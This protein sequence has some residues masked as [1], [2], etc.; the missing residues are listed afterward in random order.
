MFKKP[1]WVKNV[2]AT[3]K[4]WIDTDTG[5][6]LVAVRGLPLEEEPVKPEQ[7]RKR[8]RPTKKKEI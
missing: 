5:E 3:D 4:G 6:L 2:K 1:T 8:G 7:K